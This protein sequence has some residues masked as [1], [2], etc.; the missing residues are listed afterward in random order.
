[1]KK[2]HTYKLRA[3][4]L[5]DVLQTMDFVDRF[6][7]TRDNGY[8]DVEFDFDSKLSLNEIKARL[9][10]IEDGH[11]MLETVQLFEKYTGERIEE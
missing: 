6:C 8:P 3:E 2:S 10:G 9:R 5:H 11:V 4:C 1:M 7:I